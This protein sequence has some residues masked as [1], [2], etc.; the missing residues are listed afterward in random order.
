MIK[1]RCINCNQLGHI[2]RYCKNPLNS[3]GILLYRYDLYCHKYEYLMIQRRHTFAYVEIIRGNYHEDNKDYLQR[4][5]GEMTK[6][7]RNHI[8][9]KTFLE[10]WEDLWLFEDKSNPRF[11]RDF[12]KAS[13]TFKTMLPCFQEIHDKVPV[14]W[15]IPEWGF[16]KGKRE[17]Y[18]SIVQCAKRECFEETNIHETQ[19]RITTDISPVEETFIGTDH[20]AYRH[21]YYV[22]ELINSTDHQL[23][24]KDENKLQLREVGNM[25][26][27]SLSDALLFIR[28]Y[29]VEKKEIIRHIDRILL[30]RKHGGGERKNGEN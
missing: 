24:F 26:W 20:K 15:E 8:F 30:K 18:E 12:N 3:Y 19:Y 4:L 7:E 17:L 16:P 9:Q 10:L 25:R 11:I 28:P 1:K 5:F 14:L 29:N 13:E 2:Y 23:F 22:A 21:V 27:F 6:Q